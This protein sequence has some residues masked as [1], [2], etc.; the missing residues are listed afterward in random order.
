M[1]T[2]V[3]ASMLAINAEMGYPERREVVMFRRLRCFVRLH[4][5]DRRVNPELGGTEAVYSVCRF[6]GK[7]KSDY[8]PP[9]PG[10]SIGLGGGH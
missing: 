2:I 8:G 1:F 9:T 4:S 10:Q 7:E 5:W 3:G 6:C